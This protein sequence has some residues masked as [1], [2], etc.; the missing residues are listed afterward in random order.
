[1]S[2]LSLGAPTAESD[3]Q[4]RAVL[5]RLAELRSAAGMSQTDM[6][7]AL[8]VSRATVSR[9]EAYGTDL[10]RCPTGWSGLALLSLLAELEDAS[11]DSS[12]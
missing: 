5:P 4:V 6:A 7:R 11:G 12:D 2:I 10:G 9:W 3:A 8:G 1:M